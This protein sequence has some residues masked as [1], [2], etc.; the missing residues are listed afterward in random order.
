MSSGNLLGALFWRLRMVITD[1][2]FGGDNM[3]MRI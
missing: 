2:G 3:T 1:A